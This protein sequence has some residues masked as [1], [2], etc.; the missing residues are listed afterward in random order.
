[1]PSELTKIDDLQSNV[2]QRK[3]FITGKIA[4]LGQ[5]I[6]LAEKQLEIDKREMERFIT[7]MSEMDNVS[8]KIIEIKEDHAEKDAKD[9]NSTD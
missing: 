5:M 4:Q 2:Q 3:L 6:Y 7:M 9:D 1:M 8:T